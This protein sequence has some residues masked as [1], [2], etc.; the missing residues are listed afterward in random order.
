MN[1]QPQPYFMPARAMAMQLFVV[2]ICAR[3][4]AYAVLY[5]CFLYLPEGAVPAATLPRAREDVTKVFKTL[6]DHH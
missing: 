2:L 5:K 1:R 4:I 6:T 3:S